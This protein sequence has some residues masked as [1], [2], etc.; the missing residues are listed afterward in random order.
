MTSLARA[1]AVAELA[2]PRG[3]RCAVT[4]EARSGVFEFDCAPGRNLLYAGLAPRPDPSAR[5]RDRHL[6][7]LP[8]P[9]H[10]RR[11]R[12]RLGRRAGRREAQARQGRHPD[13][14][15]ARR[16]RLRAA[17]AS[18]IAD[19]PARHQI[20]AMRHG[21]IENVRHLTSDVT[22]FEVALSEP[23]DFDAG[24]FVVIE[25]PGLEGAR[26][27]S[28]VN[29]GHGLDRIEL[30]VK[31]KPGGGFG[32]WIAGEPRERRQGQAVRAHGPRDVP[33]G[34]GPQSADDRGRLR[35]R[36]HDVDPRARRRG[37]LLPR[38]QGPRVLRRPH[39]CGRVLSRAIRAGASI[40]ATAISRSRSR[41]P[42]RK[43][44]RPSTPGIRACGSPR[45]SSTRSRAPPWPADTTT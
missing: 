27:Y 30:V 26:A 39:A 8:G 9:R 35:H 42:T 45:A 31:R 36:R 2:A 37:G 14:P 1:D 40:A 17:R 24:Q 29:Y 33:P 3:E 11:G 41:C 21:V 25:A 13:V 18:D 16:R 15:D 20:P 5:M 12:G 6:R 22:H 4:V 10:D 23:M 7:H 43:R 28:M 44:G 38:P 34:R 19:K 32:D